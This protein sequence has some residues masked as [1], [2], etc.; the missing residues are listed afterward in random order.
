MIACI[1]LLAI[2]SLFLDFQV[3]ADQSNYANEDALGT[4]MDNKFN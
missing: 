4:S 3:S 1:P 2:L